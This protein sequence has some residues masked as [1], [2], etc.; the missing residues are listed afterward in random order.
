MWTGG[1]AHLFDSVEQP[2][3]AVDHDQHRQPQ[4]EDEQA[5]DVGVRLGRLG[6]PGDRAAGPGPLQA[7]TT[8]AQQG[9]H[10]PEQGVEPGA[11][12]GQQR[13]AVV[14]GPLV[15]HG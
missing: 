4:T 8:P 5:D 10:C 13:L 3:I 1:T 15:V 12:H 7:V 2:P 6:C 9:G 14:G 11:R